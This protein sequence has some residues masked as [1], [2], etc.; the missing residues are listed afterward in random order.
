[1]KTFKGTPKIDANWAINVNNPRQTLIENVCIID[2]GWNVPG[3]KEDAYLIASAPD[4]L[5]ALQSLMAHYEEHGQ[6]L[7]WNVDIARQAIN[8]AIL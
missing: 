7:T 2:E 5:E 3:V 4:L 8:K 1:M 6:L